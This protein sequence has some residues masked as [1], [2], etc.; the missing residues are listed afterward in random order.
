MAIHF[1][2]QLEEAF[3]P[4]EPKGRDS[5]L[6]AIPYPK[7]TRTEFV[8]TQL[9]YI[10]KRIWAASA[11]IM[12]TAA[13]GICIFPEDSLA[14]V[15]VIS[16]MIPFLGAL[17]AAELSRS[18]AF[19]MAAMESA[20]RFSLPQI[21]VARM[22][23]LGICNFVLIALLT[24]LSSK[25]TPFGFARSALCIFT[26]YITV[27]GLCLAIYN[28]VRGQDG[29]YLSAVAAMAVSVAGCIIFKNFL[30]DVRAMNLL[31]IAACIAGV[32][33]VIVQSKKIIFERD[34][35]GIKN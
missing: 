14:L 29:A 30:L 12:L 31:S 21:T 22:L 25:Y 32:V 24:V 18:D 5:F 15:W 10:R 11:A 7:L 1:K 8:L 26:P 16:A 13:G 6:A 28:R 35:Y 19:G 34:Y 9:G 33:A 4:P 3:A 20:C 2:Q 17:T 23:I 27:S